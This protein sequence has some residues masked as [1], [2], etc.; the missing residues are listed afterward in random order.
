MVNLINV[1]NVINVICCYQMLE[2]QQYV[3]CGVLYETADEPHYDLKNG[4][5]C[6]TMALDGASC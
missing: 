1:V 2:F 4:F 5:S 6:K 3:I